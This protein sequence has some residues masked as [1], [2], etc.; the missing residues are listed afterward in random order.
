MIGS[1][2]CCARRDVPV[3][4]RETIHGDCTACFICSGWDE[5]DPFDELE[6]DD[7]Q[8]GGSIRMADGSRVAL[9][10]ADA[11]A[12]W[13]GAIEA[14]KAR[15]AQMPGVEDALRVLMDAYTRLKELGWRDAIYC[16]KDGTAFEVIEPGSTGIFRC[17]Y[18]GT[19]PD[20]SWW[21]YD[22]HDIY[23]SRPILFRL[24]PADEAA[25]KA[26]MAAAAERFRQERESE[27]AQDTKGHVWAD[28]TIGKLSMTSCN[29]CG[30][31]RRADGKNSPCKGDVKIALRTAS[32]PS[33][34]LKDEV[35]VS[36]SINN[37]AAKY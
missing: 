32:P 6:A 2:D 35:A 13:D 21:L 17:H 31:I 37:S 19:W 26:K 24:Y 36:T 29:R 8:F 1:C 9:S 10:P 34:P 18:E 28:R 11:K 3:R 33:S 27:D 22:D 7:R 4:N 5:I 30:I 16:P 25:R 23:P 12:L 14:E 20:G 15:E